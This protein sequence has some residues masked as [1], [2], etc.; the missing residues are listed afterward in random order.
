MSTLLPTE[1]A[2]IGG[3]RIALIAMHSSPLEPVGSGEAGGMTIYLLG[4]AHQLALAGNTVDLF[5][6]RTDP[7]L[8]AE[9]ELEP[10]VRVFLLDDGDPRYHDKPEIPALAAAFT[11][12]LIRREP[13]DIVHSHYWLSGLAGLPAA[14]AWGVPHVQTFHTVAALTATL[15]PP[16]AGPQAPERFAG[17]ERIALESDLVIALS[18]A[19]AEKIAGDRVR[20]VSPGVDRE[21]FRP[22]TNAGYLF[23]AARLR[24][25]KG[26]DLAIC[27][28][29]EIPER[30][31]PELVVAGGGT[32]E[33]R[34]RLES[35][36]AA[37]NV[38]LRLLGS[39]DRE[40]LAEAMRAA[41]I[42]LI[43]SYSETFGLVATEAAASGVP[44]IASRA[45]GLVDAVSE[46]ES[47]L[48]VTGRDPVDWAAAIQSLLRDPARRDALGISAREYSARVEERDGVDRIR[49]LYNSLLDGTGLP[50]RP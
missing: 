10:G 24:T 41:A 20:V 26:I 17:E 29:A 12:E 27:A 44:T 38:T 49:A 7:D 28:L 5:T 19:E 8:P 33:H 15:R 25:V 48:L 32:P 21:L 39:L 45:G 46:N 40:R 42:V 47:G 50:P 18:R 14:R 16:G 35:L 22:G 34:E 36:A 4:L 9:T 3:D 13:Y 1:A 37:K 31:R 6:R 30:E 2:G 11:E 23:M 43:P